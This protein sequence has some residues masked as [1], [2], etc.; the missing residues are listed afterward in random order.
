MRKAL[1][2]ICMALSMLLSIGNSAKASGY[3]EIGQYGRPFE[4]CY[5]I[6]DSEE[7]I[8]EEVRLGDM[9][10]IAQLV[11]AE[12][13]NQSLEGKRLVACVIINRIESPYFPDNAYDVI[14]QEGQFSVTK[15]GAWEKA[16]YNMK[17]SDYEAVAIEM[18]LHSN[19]EV[20]FFNNCRKV[21]GSGD[22]FKVGD[23]WFNTL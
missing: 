7:Q 17:E 18:E 9:E 5:E 14:F 15:N 1:L 13:G 3:S 20:L 4:L 6:E 16:A 8:E 23:H 2:G 22:P 19:T 21:S 11:E 10:L 12:A